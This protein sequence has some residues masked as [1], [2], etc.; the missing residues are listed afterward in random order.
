[1]FNIIVNKYGYDDFCND[2]NP[3]SQGIY[4]GEARNAMSIVI[5]AISGLSLALYLIRAKNIKKGNADF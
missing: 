4:R 2:I 3:Q 1:L 5:I